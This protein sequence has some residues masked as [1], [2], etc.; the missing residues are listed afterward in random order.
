MTDLIHSIDLGK[1]GKIKKINFLGDKI[2][3]NGKLQSLII[4]EEYK[5][6]KFISGRKF[7][8]EDTISLDK[9]LLK[10]YYLNKGYYNVKI[11]SSFAKLIKED[12]FELIFNI[13]A[14]SKFFFGEV[15]ITLPSDFDENGYNELKNFV[16]IKGE[17]YSINTVEKILDKIDLITLNEEFKSINAEV[18]ENIDQ[19]KLNLEFIINETEKFYVEKINIYGNNVT[20]ENVIRNQLEI[21]EGDLI[22]KF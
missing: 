6:W 9:R 15:D 17:P 10:N 20:R 13:D 2:F 1:K 4:S 5:F 8:N 22:T 19:D 11:N 14:G 7:L 12:E 16:K 3:K 21:D 18:S